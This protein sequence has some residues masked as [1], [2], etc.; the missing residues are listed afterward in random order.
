MAQLSDDE[1]EAIT[2]GA[3]P[4]NSPLGPRGNAGVF[5]GVNESLRKKGI[6]PVAAAYGSAGVGVYESCSLLPS[7]TLLACTFDQ[8]LVETVARHTAQEMRTRGVQVLLAPG[9]NLHRNPLCGRNF[10]YF[11]EDPLSGG[12][13][14]SRLCPGHP[15]RRV[16]RLPRPLRL[17]QSGEK[18]AQSRLRCLGAGPPGAVSQGL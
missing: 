15:V 8:E 9:M 5:G 1:L 7:G 6:P 13:N 2:R 14:G 16:R 17:Q 3:G 18:P 12:Q 4:M 10:E 11:S